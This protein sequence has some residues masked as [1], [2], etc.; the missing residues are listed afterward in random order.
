MPEPE[1]QDTSAPWAPMLFGK[2][3]HV[4]YRS[5]DDNRETGAVGTATHEAHSVASKMELAYSRIPVEMPSD[6][7]LCILT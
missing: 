5:P 7:N 4:L 6:Y 2:T 3:F 1:Q